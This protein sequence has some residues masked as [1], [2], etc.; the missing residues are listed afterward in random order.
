MPEPENLND[1]LKKL[2]EAPNIASK[3]WV[4]RQYDTSVR[5]STVI[6]PGSDAAVIRVR[7]TSK[8]LAV[9][10]DCNGRWCYLNPRSGGMHAVCEAALNVACSGAEPVAITNCLNFGNPYDPEI[11]YTFAEAVAG[12]GEACRILNT[13]VT[14]G[15]VSF[16]NEDINYE[17]YPSPVIGMVGVLND[18]NKRLTSFFQQ[19]G[20]II[21]LIGDNKGE[22]GGSE[23]IKTIHNKVAGSIPS[24][25]PQSVKDVAS[26]L[27]ELADSELLHCAHDI[28]DGG[29]AVALAECCFANEIGAEIT[30][31]SEL[32][33]DAM[34]FGESRP[35]VV[36]SFP[37]QSQSSILELCKNKNIPVSIIGKTGGSNLKINDLINCSVS[38][39]RD[40]YESAIPRMMEKISH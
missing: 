29:L 6:G 9:S 3:R 25:S 1:V 5:T 2:L 28:S 12:I 34:L 37:G 33:N 18:I 8:G 10:T 39:L 19:E 35:L 4:Y 21:A 17:V 24:I 27:V 30:I 11:Y 40:I 31:S 15:N 38:E 32:R 7:K 23:Y 20:D 22:L 13:P 16:Y 26:L 36:I 14:G